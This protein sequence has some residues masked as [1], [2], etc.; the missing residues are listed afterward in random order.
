MY[1]YKGFNEN[2]CTFAVSGNVVAGSIVNICDNCTVKAAEAGEDFCGVVTNTRNGAAAVQLTGYA[3]LTYSG[4]G[5]NV[6][7]G[8]FAADGNGGIA[9][10]EDGVK[11]LVV[12]VDADTKK[13]G[14]IF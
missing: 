6:G 9:A 11:L 8:T 3:E 2:V 10:A 13:V 12:C 5:V 1:S 7:F 4:E 14:V